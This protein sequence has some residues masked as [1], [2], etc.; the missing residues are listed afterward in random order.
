VSFSMISKRLIA[1]CREEVVRLSDISGLDN[2]TLDDHTAESSLRSKDSNLLLEVGIIYDEPESLANFLFIIRGLTLSLNRQRSID[3]EER[4]K[5]G[6]SILETLSNEAR[7]EDMQVNMVRD[8]ACLLIV[9]VMSRSIYFSMRAEAVK[10]GIE[11]FFNGN[12]ES[13]NSILC[14]LRWNNMAGAFFTALNGDLFR[15]TQA[16]RELALNQRPTRSHSNQGKNSS[17]S[18]IPI[19]NAEYVC[20]LFRFLQL[21]CEGHNHDVQ[22]LLEIKSESADTKRFGLLS[23]AISLL[24]EY[25]PQRDQ[26]SLDF[27]TLRKKD[28][29]VIIH[30]MNFLIE[31]V[32]GP[33]PLNQDIIS[34]DELIFDILSRIFYAEGLPLDPNEDLHSPLKFDLS[35]HS[36]LP[37]SFGMLKY[38]K[39]LGLELR[40]SL[41]EGRVL[42]TDY[43]LTIIGRYEPR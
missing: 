20:C 30:V 28:A 16:K 29:G 23:Q 8:G 9:E 33:C 27:S 32:Q 17:E 36:D 14:Y 39:I 10:F 26:N 1:F 22:S 34:K 24:N 37:I 3:D 4:M 7:F 15:I 31:A 12:S 43:A 40:M 11:V 18:I 2:A 5:T 21:L 25:V 6:P 35:C 19:L 41:L 38:L 13:Q 42:D